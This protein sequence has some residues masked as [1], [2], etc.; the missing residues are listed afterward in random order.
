MNNEHLFKTSS[1][2]LSHV[3]ICT[4]MGTTRCVIHEADLHMNCL[5]T[6]QQNQALTKIWRLGTNT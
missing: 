1:Q 2:T 4:Y 3:N 5:V 6:Q